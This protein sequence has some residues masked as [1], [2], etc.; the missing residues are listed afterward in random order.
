MVYSTGLCDKLPMTDWKKIDVT[1]DEESQKSYLLLLQETVHEKG[2]NEAHNLLLA[3]ILLLRT[4][5][6]QSSLHE[7]TTHPQAI[8]VTMSYGKLARLL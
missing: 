8:K 7:Q 3:S 2:G 4:D 5:V 6:L 1:I